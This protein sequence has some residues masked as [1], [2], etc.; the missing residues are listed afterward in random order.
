MRRRVRHLA[1]AVA[2]GSVAVLGSFA[3]QARASGSAAQDQYTPPSIVKPSGGGGSMTPPGAQ[4]SA[5]TGTAAQG[6]TLPFTGLSLLK[7]VL[8][9]AGLLLLGILLRRGVPRRGP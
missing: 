3:G 6:S 7:V 4:A 1:V 8:V 9:G 2:V 5:P